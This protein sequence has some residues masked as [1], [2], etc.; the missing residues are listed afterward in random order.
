MTQGPHFSGPFE[1]MKHGQYT[2][3]RLLAQGHTRSAAARKLNI[4]EGGLRHRMHALRKL[5]GTR[6][7]LQLVALAVVHGVITLEDI[8]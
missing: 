1:K 3:L 5:T 8:Q 4:S 2:A 7:T 6:S